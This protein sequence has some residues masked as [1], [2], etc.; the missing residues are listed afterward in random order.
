MTI[1]GSLPNPEWYKQQEEKLF[2]YLK[3]KIEAERLNPEID[4]EGE[5]K[6]KMLREIATCDLPAHVRRAL[7]DLLEKDEDDE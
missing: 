2:N 3:A 1:Y 7:I 4:Y 5:L 6:Y